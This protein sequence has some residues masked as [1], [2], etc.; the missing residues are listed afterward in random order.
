MFQLSH[1]SR[2]PLGG[3]ILSQNWPECCS[4]LVLGWGCWT[5][6]KGKQLIMLVGILVWAS[7]HKNVNYLFVKFLFQQQDRNSGRPNLK[8]YMNKQT[9]KCCLDHE[10]RKG[11][12]RGP[13]ESL[14]SAACKSV[15]L[16]TP[17]SIGNDFLNNG[18]KVGPAFFQNSATQPGERECLPHP[19]RSFPVGEGLRHPCRLIVCSWAQPLSPSLSLPICKMKCRPRKV[20]RSFLPDILILC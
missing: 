5:C 10:A 7:P 12:W 8:R 11:G 1:L 4:C 19:H 17:G 13:S 15:D 2:W 20:E 14:T 18:R 3:W 9:I 16:E 6:A